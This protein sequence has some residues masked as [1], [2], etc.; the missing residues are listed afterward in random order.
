MLRLRKSIAPLLS[1]L[2]L[3]TT[4]TG[5]AFAQADDP[6]GSDLSGDVPIQPCPEA[7]AKAAADAPVDAPE[8]MVGDLSGEEPLTD[9]QQIEGSATPPAPMKGDLSGDEPTNQPSIDPTQT[10]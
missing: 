5:F 10:N 4:L 2:F 3:S 8:S 1:A 7:D 6:C 9:E